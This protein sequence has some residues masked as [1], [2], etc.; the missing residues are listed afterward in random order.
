[1]NKLSGL[2]WI[3]FGVAIS[4]IA[5]SFGFFK[6]FVP[7]QQEA[8]YW[9]EHRDALVTEGNKGPQAD[10]RLLLAEE[11]VAEKTSQWNAVVAT[12][13][14]AQSVAAGGIN[15]AVNPW[16]LTVDARTYRN[17]VQR[18]VNGQLRR[19][20]VE[21]VQGPLVP[22]PDEAPP[23]VLANYFNYP[24]LP[25]PVVIFDLGTVTVQGTYEQITSHVR[26]FSSMPR[27][28][29]LADGLQISGTSPRLTGTYNLQVVGFM[30]GDTVFTMPEGD[31]PAA[32]AMGG[33][34][35][36]AGPPMGPGG[37]GPGGGG[38]PGAPPPPA[39]GR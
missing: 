27:Y 39:L 34:Q 18:A 32:P 33:M 21:V 6:H 19:G 36:M 5:L 10:R 30:R 20:G 12:R 31:A 16:Q 8:G 13:T 23:Q 24:A 37:G 15:L 28:L 38:P 22:F 9:R 25:F 3:I 11:M 29:A 4:I 26:A 2:T 14:P 7:N 17:N 35:P 1:M